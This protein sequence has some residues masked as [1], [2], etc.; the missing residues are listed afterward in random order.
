M[1]LYFA[2]VVN[3]RNVFVEEIK[4]ILFLIYE[5]NIGNTYVQQ[6]VSTQR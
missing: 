5:E 3:T 2:F 1:H 6:I 4:E